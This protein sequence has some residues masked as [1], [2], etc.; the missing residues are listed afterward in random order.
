MTDPD[1]QPAVAADEAQV[2]AAQVGASVIH[3]PDQSQQEPAPQKGR[4]ADTPAK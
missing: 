3:L 4:A 2:D 1:D